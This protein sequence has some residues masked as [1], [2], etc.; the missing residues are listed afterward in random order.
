[1]ICASSGFSPISLGVWRFVLSLPVP[2]FPERGSVGFY[3][4]PE[5]LGALSALPAIRMG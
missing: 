5:G 2:S 4:A 3:G 1:M